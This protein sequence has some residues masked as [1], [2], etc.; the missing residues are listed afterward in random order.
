MSELLFDGLTYLSDAMLFL[1]GH[2]QTL[3]TDFHAMRVRLGATGISGLSMQR[4]NQ[5]LSDLSGYSLG[6]C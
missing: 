6:V 2:C 1:I 3:L 5:F 4:M